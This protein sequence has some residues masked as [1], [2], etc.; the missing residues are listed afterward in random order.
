[1]PHRPQPVGPANWRRRRSSL[2][3]RSGAIHIRNSMPSGAA[4]MS[5][6]SMS[7]G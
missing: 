2:A 7:P 5:N 6:S 1:M 3:I 4:T